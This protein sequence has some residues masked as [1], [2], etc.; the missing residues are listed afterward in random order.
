MIKFD[1][2]AVLKAAGAMGITVG[3]AAS[4]FPWKAAKAQGQSTV[5]IAVE[6]DLEG[7]LAPPFRTS[8][9]EGNI[10]RSVCEGLISFDPGTYEWS[11]EAAESIEQV[12]PTEIAFTLK[13]GR[14][15]H[16]GYG[17]MTAEDVKWSFEAYANLE[18]DGKPS[19]YRADWAALDR[20]EVTGKYSGRILLTSP[21]PQLWLVVLPEVSGLIFSKAAWDD[22]HYRPENSPVKVIG[23]GPYMFAEWEPNQQIVLRANP[24]YAGPAPDFEAVNLRVVRDPK[25]AELALRSDELQFATIEPASAA[26]M[27]EIA[28]TEVLKLDS[29]NIVW[30]GINVEKE[31]FTDPRVREAIRAAIDIEQ[32]VQGAYDGAVSRANSIIAPRI[33]G[34]WEDAPVYTR[35]VAKARSLLQEA[36]FGRG[37]DT[38]LTLLNRPAYQSIGQIVQAMLSEIGINLELEV[39]D[40]GSFWSMGNGEQ[41]ENLDMALQR[42]GGKAD[43]AFITQWFTPEQIG[44][45]NWQ[46][47]NSA[48]Y[49]E[50]FEKAGSTSDAA[51]RAQAYIRMQQLMDESK[52]FIWLT[53]EANTYAYRDWLAPAILPNGDDKLYDAFSRA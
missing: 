43:P 33:L 52:A 45:W 18:V 10:I 26:A 21:A 32:V 46:R 40:G 35:D 39:L 51:E 20:V 19:S 3:A 38:R 2:R 53:H 47:W 28:D 37:F 23:T 42:F 27:A 31:P 29:I 8:F 4:G 22:G 12:S 6:R 1:R 48:E 41:G 24:D 14:M 30:L 50:L 17:E 44:E 49:G 11:L 36:G 5:N 7:L 15:F 25:T 13:P 9:Q 34:H 16:D